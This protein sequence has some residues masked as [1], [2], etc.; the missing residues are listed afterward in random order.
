LDNLLLNLLDLLNFNHS[1]D[2]L[3]L[4]DNRNCVGLNSL[5]PYRANRGRLNLNNGGGIGLNGLNVLDNRDCV[6]LNG[7]NAKR[8]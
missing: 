6:G 8:Y 3:N 7:L 2:L 5:H 4:L 1:L